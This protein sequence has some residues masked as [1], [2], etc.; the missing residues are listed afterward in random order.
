M[1]PASLLSDLEFTQLVKGTV[2][3][4]ATSSK[5]HRPKV[6]K[7]ELMKVWGIIG[8]EAAERTLQATTQLVVRNAL[9]PI[10]RRFRAEVAQLRY[11]RLSGR[12]GRFYS[13]TMFGPKSLRQNS[14]CQIFCNDVDFVKCIPMRMKM[15]AGDALEEFLQD[16][17]IPAD[18]H[19]D[20]AKELNLAKWGTVVKKFGIRQTQTE[21]YTPEQNRAELTIREV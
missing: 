4:S 7:E 21:A 12:H 2:L 14:M 8:L 3:V 13:D 17:G 15:Q 16:V 10:G 9:H 5:N 6:Q 18:M 19:V 1:S 11:N 20:E